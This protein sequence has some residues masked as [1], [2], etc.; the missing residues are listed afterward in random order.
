APGGPAA[1]AGLQPGDVILAADG[2]NL[3]NADTPSLAAALTGPQGST[4]SLSIDRGN[5]PQTIGVSRG[6]YYFP[7]LDSRILPDGVGYLR[8]SDFVISGPTLPN[9][10]E[11][12]ADFG[13]P[14]DELHALG[15]Q[16]WI[17]DLRNNVGGS[18]QTT[19]ELLGRFLPDT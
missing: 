12:V 13:L 15:A 5:G 3:A 17:L 2:K 4:V 18:L 19:D 11:L 6:P 10:T 14:L 9:G 8:L 16:S 7:P 1:T